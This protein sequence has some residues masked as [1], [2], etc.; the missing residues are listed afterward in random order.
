MLLKICPNNL[1]FNKRKH[2]FKFEMK[3]LSRRQQ[4]ND[5]RTDGSKTCCVKYTKAIKGT[6]S[7][8]KG[9]NEVDMSNT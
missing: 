1:S 5:R 3:I 6:K 7:V 8:S 9:D 4:S 2:H